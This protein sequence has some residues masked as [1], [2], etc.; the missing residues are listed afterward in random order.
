MGW[1]EVVS[2][3]ITSISIQDQAEIGTAVGIAGSIRSVI[4]TV[5]SAVYTVILTNRLAKTIPEEVPPK[6]IAAG[7]PS[8]SVA[9]F[10]SAVS[11]GTPAAFS[12]VPGLTGAIEATGITAYKVASSHAYQTVFYS[13]LAFSLIAILMAALSPNVEDQMTDTVVATLH[14]K[15]D[16][17]RPEK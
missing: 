12:K 10:L 15:D 2:L 5:A 1:L 13:T 14:H 6:L 9:S 16:E 7:L 17:V 4:S 11:V 8:T 3:A